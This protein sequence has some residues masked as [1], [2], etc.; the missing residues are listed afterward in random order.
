MSALA[1][2]VSTAAPPVQKPALLEVR[3]LV[4]YYPG[5]GSWLRPRAIKAVDD[6]S[7]SIGLA[8]PWGWSVS[9]VAA[10][11]PPPRPYCA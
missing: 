9:R 7:F 8:K 6:I 1:V 3:K 10:N 11:R 4:K 5:G 2:E